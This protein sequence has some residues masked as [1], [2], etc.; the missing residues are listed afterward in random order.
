[1]TRFLFLLALLPFFSAAQPTPNP[2]P[3]TSS[4]RR[5]ESVAARRDA[6]RRSWLGTVPLRNVGPTVMS[7]RVVDL[8]VNP[9]DP[10]EFY[11]AYAS[12]GLWHTHNNG[13]S[14]TPVLDTVATM[15]LGDIAVHWGKTTADHIVWAGTGE[16]NSS[17][18]SYSGVGMY[19]STN[20][21]KTWAWLGLP[22]SQHIGR[23]V[24]HP[25]D[26]STAWVAVLGNLYSPS[27]ARGVYRTT[28]AGKTWTHVLKSTDNLTGAI[29]L[30]I[31]PANPATLYAATWQRTRRA[32]N[33]EESGDGTAIW[34]STD[35]GTTWIKL[36]T[37]QSG[38]PS[39]AKAGRIGLSS[40]SDGKTLFAIIDHQGYRDQ[41]KGTEPLITKAKLKTMDAAAFLALPPDSLNTFL[42]A[43]G[44]P[45]DV[46]AASLLDQVK[47]GKLKPSAL[48]D[49]LYSANDDLF[50][51]PIRGAELY[52]STDGGATWAKTHGKPL[53][54]LFFTYGYYFAQVRVD[55]LNAQR[56]YLLGVPAITSTDGGKTWSA[57]MNDNS[58]SDHH[59][60]WLS[61]TRAGHLVLGN[62]GGINVSYDHGKTFVHAN[63][64]AVGQFY[65]VQVDQAK[66]YNVYG[67]L[68]D[69]GVWVGPS[70]YTHSYDW[71]SDGAYPYKR[72]YGGDGMQV[73]VDP[74]DN[75]TVYTG[76]QFGNYSRV[77][78]L[79]GAN[80]FIT[81]RHTLGE[82][83]YRWNWQTPI[84]LS[85]HNADI[86]YMGAHRVLRSFN[87]G[88]AFEAISPD[89]TRGAV[90]GDVPFGTL[91]CL[92]ESPLRFGLLWAGSDDGLVH[93]S[94]D[95]GSSW[96]NVSAG[97]PEW[98]W[99]SR[100][101]VSKHD[102]ATAL[103][104][105]NGY[106]WDHFESYLYRT[107][108]YGKTWT[109]LGA[110]GDAPLPAEPIN[111]V[112]QDPANPKLLYVGTDHGLYASLDGG[113]RWMS[114]GFRSLPETPVHDLA[115]QAR[116]REMLVG[117]HGRSLYIAP[118]RHIQA[119]TGE[120]TAKAL[121]A[122]SLDTLTYSDAWG[123]RGSQWNPARKPSTTLTYW[124]KAAG[125]LQLTLTA[126]N[127][128]VLYSTT[129][130]ATAGLNY[131]PLSLA[132]DSASL[133]AALAPAP[134]KDSDKATEK[135][136]EKEKA[137]K[138]APKVTPAA[139]GSFYLRAGTY[140]LRLTQGADTAEVKLVLKPQRDRPRRGGRTAT[141]PD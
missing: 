88:D 1:M 68:Q 49:Y 27:P 38:F 63:S 50:N 53:D 92:T 99:V 11:V 59:A 119:L 66:P 78:R 37:P 77:N 71:Y 52:T 46:T 74:R 12:G 84:H 31:D 114:L 69:N 60:L 3:A 107:T 111:V 134:P 51:T 16:N 124:A 43:N 25:T 109:R 44:F 129:D 76:L 9:A 80:K 140:T 72:L 8:D 83:P 15:T 57:L 97:L 75:A 108:N 4:A 70:T 106:R 112:R 132:A 62:D 28:D 48:S 141:N 86:L 18:S 139:D 34:K 133:V 136:P 79:T 26:A 126:E 35:A 58:H 127:G 55:P 6:Q 93:V 40:S 7:G 131:Q 54:D 101:E 2:L 64:P 5:L 113:T 96:Q 36:S 39:G 32:W 94:R 117:T 89:L 73:Q 30:L 19:R 33:F 65:A 98:L 105:L 123:R 14:F 120:L 104:A 128:T 125:T 10:S 56:L 130:T 95:G 122:F 61:P 23:I 24:L 116:E 85:V 87:R 115:I 47:A 103:V 82:R 29:D 135:A 42:D 137:Q 13:Q 90:P 21:G 102:T 110:T 45:A 81:P 17:R 118:L 121:H 100:I 138:P 22:E 91:S 67:G 41:P 20:G